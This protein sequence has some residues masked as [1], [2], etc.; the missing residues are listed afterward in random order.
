MGQSECIPKK[1]DKPAQSARPLALT[2]GRVLYAGRPSKGGFEVFRRLSPKGGNLDSW[3][4]GE[5][6]DHRRG[7]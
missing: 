7:P 4:G 3:S 1:S 2:L 5:P 6:G